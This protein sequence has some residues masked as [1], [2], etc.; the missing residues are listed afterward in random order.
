M[1]AFEFPALKQYTFTMEW[2]KVQL[3]ERRG[4]DEHEPIALTFDGDGERS[5]PRLPRP[6]VK[7]IEGLDLALLQAWPTGVDPVGAVVPQRAHGVLKRAA[8]IDGARRIYV[9]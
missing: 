5:R 9:R 7:L 4:F 1:W 8:C 2:I 3:V 6:D